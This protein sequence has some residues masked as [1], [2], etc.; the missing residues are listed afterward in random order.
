MCST[1]IEKYF[2]RMLG[3]VSFVGIKVGVG[4]LLNFLG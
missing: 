1:L 4:K 3:K 2:V